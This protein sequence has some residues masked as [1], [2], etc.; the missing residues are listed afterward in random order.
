MLYSRDE[1]LTPLVFDDGVK[2]ETYGQSVFVRGSSLLA[3]LC[4]CP[5]RD[6]DILMI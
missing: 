1:P 3:L 5:L 4:C 2:G 6:G